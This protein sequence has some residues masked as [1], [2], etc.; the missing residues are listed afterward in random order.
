MLT[1]S[2]R[3]I[4]APPARRRLPLSSRE[5]VL[6][7]VEGRAGVRL[8]SLS[9]GE[10]RKDP[11]CFRD[12][13]ADSGRV[14]VR[15]LSLDG[16][17]VTSTVIL[18]CPDDFGS[19]AKDLTL[20]LNVECWMLNEGRARLLP[21]RC[22]SAASAVHVSVPAACGP[23][24]AQGDRYPSGRAMCCQHLIPAPSWGRSFTSVALSRLVPEHFGENF[25]IGAAI[26]CGCP[27]PV[28]S[29]T[30]SGVTR[31]PTQKAPYAPPK[32]PAPVSQT[33]RASASGSRGNSRR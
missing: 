3:T 18:T 25:G 7:G 27:G 20:R 28:Q 9:L 12:R 24:M 33:P 6:S 10:S 16:P 13:A 4:Q 23:R 1:D 21:S 11:E 14:G 26:P 31:S 29:G 5:P 17:E 19:A 2:L 22:H 15:A 8:V 32:A 30:C